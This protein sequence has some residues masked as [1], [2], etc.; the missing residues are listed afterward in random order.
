MKKLN[1]NEIE[2]VGGGFV[3]QGLSGSLNA[4]A[5]GYGYLAGGGSVN[6]R[7]FSATIGGAFL[8]GA[9]SPARTA[10]NLL[11]LGT[12]GFVAGAVSGNDSEWLIA[13]NTTINRHS[14][15]KFSLFLQLN[16]KN[17]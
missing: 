10:S 7:G 9:I 5:A 13:V 3:V 16:E 1:L 2:S 11:L 15:E 6:S 8:A 4:L 14:E 17:N 12:A